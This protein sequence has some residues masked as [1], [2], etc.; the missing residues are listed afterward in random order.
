MPLIKAVV[1]MRST[2]EPQEIVELEKAAEI[3]YRMH[4]TAMRLTRAGVTE[5]FVGGQVDGVAN[6]YGAMVSF[7][8]IYSQ[9]GEIMHGNPA[10]AVLSPDA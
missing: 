5:K 9:H 1:K 7:P 10:M 3:G 8:T 6:S 4:T 2:K